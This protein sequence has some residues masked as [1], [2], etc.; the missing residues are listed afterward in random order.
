MYTDGCRASQEG[1]HLV[2]F[3]ND[4]ALLSLLQAWL[5]MILSKT[6][7]LIT[8]FRNTSAEPKNS[9]I[10]DEPVQIVETYKY[11][12]TTFDSNL[13]FNKNTV[14]CKTEATKNLFYVP[15]IILS[16]SLL[17]FSFICWFDGFSVKDKN[18]LN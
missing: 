9:Q 17:I 12:E 14:T 16:L 3:S 15:F 13:K 8:D 2:K 1:C 5:L 10:H 4:T 7:E 18:C 6:K 11:S